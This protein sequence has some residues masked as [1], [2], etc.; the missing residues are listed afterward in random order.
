MGEKRNVL[1]IRRPDVA[2]E[3]L[4]LKNPSI[5]SRQKVEPTGQD[6]AFS[7]KMLRKMSHNTNRKFS[8]I[9]PI[10]GFT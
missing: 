7:T 6:S 1:L 5:T 3:G 4:G 9:C 8:V 10:R 2:R